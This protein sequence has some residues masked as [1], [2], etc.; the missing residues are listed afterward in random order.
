[1]DFSDLPRHIAI[2]PDGNRRWAK[3]HNLHSME[4]HMAGYKTMVNLI[5][6][7]AKIGIKYLTFFCF[8]T[9]NRSRS[10]EELSYLKGLFKKYIKANLNKLSQ[11]DIRLKV[12]G[13]LSYF[14]TDIQETI[15]DSVEKTAS[16]SKLTLT[17]A[18]NYGGRDEIAH[19]VKSIAYELLNGK[20]DIDEISEQSFG[21]YLYTKD[22]PDPDLLIRTSGEYRISNFLLWQIAY[23]E[24]FFSKKFFPDFQRE[25]LHAAIKDFETRNRRFGK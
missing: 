12:I 3:H 7:A 18:L 15:K 21:K 20:I 23:S 1:M 10:D 25:D 5:D 22:L 2:I 8:S 4:G 13:D 14:G 19:A 16:C 17:I 6:E 9:E 24:L 11:D